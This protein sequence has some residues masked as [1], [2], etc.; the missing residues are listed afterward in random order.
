M[1]DS[2]TQI[3]GLLVFYTENVDTIT[4][5]NGLAETIAKLDQNEIKTSLQSGYDAYQ[6]STQS[7][8]DLCGMAIDRLGSYTRLLE[9]FTSKKAKIQT[10]ILLQVLENGIEKSSGTEEDLIQISSDFSAAKE[11]IAEFEEG[12]LELEEAINKANEAK[13]KLK[14]QI[15]ALIDTKRNVQASL[16]KI[17][18]VDDSQDLE[19]VLNAEIVPLVSKLTVSCRHYRE[20]HRPN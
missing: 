8:F 6:R 11:K 9:N 20:T 19:D 15:S 5:W 14:V 17:N 1:L 4:P 12:G 2:L 16:D 18:D 3:S 13:N 10:R 7:Y